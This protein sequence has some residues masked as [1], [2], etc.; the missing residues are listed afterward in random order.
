MDLRLILVAF[1]GVIVGATLAIFAGGADNPVGGVPGVAMYPQVSLENTITWNP[2]STTTTYSISHAESGSTFLISA[3]GTVMTLPPI[4][5]ELSYKFRING[6]L[7]DSTN[8]PFVIDSY[9]GD[10]IEG[11]LIV[12][13][14]V[15]DCAAEDQI[16][17]SSTAENI[18]DY[19]EVFSDGT[20]WLI[21][22]SGAL[23]AGALTCTDPS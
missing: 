22:D 9:E 4:R 20:Q 21:G 6:A 14:A 8:A 16:N 19:F 10:N 15:V 7:L 5:D 1:A 17:A 11:T 12:A 23:T 18:G 13:G 2:T 3:S